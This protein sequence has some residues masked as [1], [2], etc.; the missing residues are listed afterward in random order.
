MKKYQIPVEDHAGTGESRLYWTDSFPC[1]RTTFD[2]LFLTEKP[3]ESN[4]TMASFSRVNLDM[5]IRSLVVAGTSK[6]FLNLSDQE[7]GR[8]IR[9]TCDIKS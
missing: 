1:R 7:V 3:V 8:V 6:I 4:S 5:L 2:F 9:P